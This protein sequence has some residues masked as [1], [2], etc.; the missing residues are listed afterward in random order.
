MIRYSVERPRTETTLHTAEV[1]HEYIFTNINRPLIA[2]ESSFGHSVSLP[3][4]A[5]RGAGA[6][7]SRVGC[8]Q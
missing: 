3:I 8:R 1:H 7:L 6:G 5:L 4:I 2:R